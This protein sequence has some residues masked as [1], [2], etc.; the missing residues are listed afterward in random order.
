MTTKNYIFASIFTGIYDVNRNEILPDDVFD[1][2]REWYISVQQLGLNGVI[3]HNTFSQKTVERYQTAQIKF[4][5]IEYDTRL[6]PNVFRYFCYRNFLAQHASMVESVFVT[7]IADVVVLQNPFEHALFVANPNALFCGDEPEILH[8]PWMYQHAT[9]LRERIADY[10]DYE[11][12]YANQTLLNC[13]II[14][15]RLAIM[16]TLLQMLTALHEAHSIGNQTTS[17]L[18]MGAFNYVARSHFEGQLLHGAP[19]NTTFKK[20]ETERIDCWFRHK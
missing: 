6:K 19:I 2:I 7:D 12:Q 10:A 1:I 13:G 20:Y 11:Q 16:Q 9:R 8:N 5:Y 17:T 14:G 3:F 18:D 4:I 15:G